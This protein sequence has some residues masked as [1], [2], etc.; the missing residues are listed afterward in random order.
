M[1][2]QLKLQMR[3]VVRDRNGPGEVRNSNC[4]SLRNCSFCPGESDDGEPSSFHAVKALLWLESM[5]KCS[6]MPWAAAGREAIDLQIDGSWARQGHRHDNSRLRPRPRGPS[7]VAM[8][9]T[10]GWPRTPSLTTSSVGTTPELVAF[11]RSLPSKPNIRNAFRT[12]LS[13]PLV[14]SSRNPSNGG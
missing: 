8:T 12:G 6:K 13:M 7:V 5:R 14:A 2:R 1:P 4:P 10:S 9:L 3:G 11:T